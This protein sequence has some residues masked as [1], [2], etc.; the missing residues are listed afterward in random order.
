VSSYFESESDGLGVHFA[1]DCSA[2]ENLSTPMAA[3]AAGAVSLRKKKKGKLGISGLL[4]LLG[5][6]QRKL[7]RVCVGLASKPNHRRERVRFLGLTKSGVGW[8]PG[9]V[10]SFFDKSVEFTSKR[11]N[12]KGGTTQ[13]YKE[14][15]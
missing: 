6:I 1:V 14:Y 13:L 12:L 5:Q 10:L 7:D 8:I 15:N 3:A 9:L 11:A 2:L 4:R